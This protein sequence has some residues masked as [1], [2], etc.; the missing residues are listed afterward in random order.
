MLII[1]RFEG[2]FAVVETSTGMVNIP[3]D[4]I[5]KEAK[6]G[7]VLS[8]SVNAEKTDEQADRINK[9]ADKLFK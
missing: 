2:H 4:D 6:V 3:T 5:P 8:L 9:L 1:D 7:S